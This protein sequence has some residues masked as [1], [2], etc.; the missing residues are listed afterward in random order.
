MYNLTFP[1]VLRLDFPYLFEAEPVGLRLTVTS[2]IEL[3]DH[4]LRE[5]SVASFGKQSDTR[6]KFHSALERRFGLARP[7]Y[8]HVIRRHAFD[9]SILGVV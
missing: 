5:T 9:R 7:R 3:L 8:A 6:M 4:L 1:E 2:E